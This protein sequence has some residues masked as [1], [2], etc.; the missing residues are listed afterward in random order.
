M[1]PNA[2]SQATAPD[3][4]GF[5]LR[6][7]GSSAFLVAVNLIPVVGVLL[8]N[9][10]VFRI[11]ALFWFENVVLGLFGIA[12]LVSASDFPSGRRRPFIPLFFLLH[13]GLFMAAHAMVLTS[14]FGPASPDSAEQLLRPLGHA[15]IGQ[16][17]IVFL[18][19]VTVSHAWSFYGHVISGGERERI[20]TG[21]AMTLPYRRMAV[22][23]VALIAGGYFVQELG[24]PLLGLLVLV[25]LKIGLD[26]NFHIKEHRRLKHSRPGTVASP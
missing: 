14:I 1:T 6:L 16:G 11:M 4:D 5:V 22:T 2:N 17:G 3:A 8:F 10:D 12:R 23:H 20:R 24:S 21:D 7:T 25:V 9:W 18:A 19:A 26:L 13:Y 15:L